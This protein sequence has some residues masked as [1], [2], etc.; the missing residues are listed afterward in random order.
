MPMTFYASLTAL[1]LM[2]ALSHADE[3]SLAIAIPV[4]AGCAMTKFEG[5]IYAAIWFCVLL[6]FCWRHRWL[7]KGVLWKFLS[8]TSVC[9]LPFVWYRLSKPVPYPLSDWWRTAIALP[10]PVLACLPRAWFLNFFSRFFDSGFFHW[11]PGEGV[12]MKWVGKWDGLNSIVNE[13]LGLLPWLLIFLLVFS[14]WKKRSRLVILCVSAVVLG[15][16]TILSFV[17]SCLAYKQPGVPEL[18]NMRYVVDYC[19]NLEMGRY[20]FPF[21]A[22]WFLTVVAVWF[23]EPEPPPAAA[24]AA[25]P[26]KLPTERAIP[27]KRR[28]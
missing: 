22:A 3:F 27:S 17:I 28:R 4:V 24:P 18:F 7:K 25:S 9:L 13:Q 1:L 21:F 12:D 19:A 2:N 15:E 14:L 23:N 11:A 6:P 5:V 26:D 10:Q 20:Y 8:A 16:F